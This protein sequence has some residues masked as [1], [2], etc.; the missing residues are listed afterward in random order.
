MKNFLKII[1][2]LHLREQSL[3]ETVNNREFW[4]AILLASL[5]LLKDKVEPNIEF[6]QRI[7]NSYTASLYTQIVKLVQ[8]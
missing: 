5:K 3:D 2:K 6:N 7:G 8:R 1:L 4:D